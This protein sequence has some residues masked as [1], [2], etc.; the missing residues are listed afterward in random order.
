MALKEC[1]AGTWTEL[2]S[3]AGPSTILVQRL[4]L[5]NVWIAVAEAAEKPADSVAGPDDAM[6]ARMF[7]VGDVFPAWYSSEL[8]GTS[9]RVYARPSTR[10]EGKVK[11]LAVEDI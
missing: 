1:T 7:L 4:T 5:A 10:V 2:T 3:A 9:L 8:N 6:D 11:M